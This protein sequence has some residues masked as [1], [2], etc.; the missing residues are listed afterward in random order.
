MWSTDAWAWRA[1]E[2]RQ[3]REGVACVARP[4]V[5]S[6]PTEPRSGDSKQ[7][8]DDTERSEVSACSLNLLKYPPEHTA[9]FFEPPC[10]CFGAA[11]WG[12]R[13]GMIGIWRVNVPV[14]QKQES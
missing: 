9:Y 5:A 1:T 6:T 7:G 3:A 4:G 14:K 8:Q 2:G 12:D 10:M 11:R 13:K